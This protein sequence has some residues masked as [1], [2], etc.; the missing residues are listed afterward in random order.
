M[1]D[2][3]LLELP[4][5]PHCDDDRAGPC[6][7]DVGVAEPSHVPRQPPDPRWAALSEL[8]LSSTT[9]KEPRWPSPSARPPGRRPAVARAANWR[10]EAPPR[11]LCPNCGAVKLPHVVC[12]NCGWYRG[13]QVIEVD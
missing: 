2:T 7:P 3:V 8:D 1:R 13:R 6:T 11:S 9:D 12:D 4:L 5:A 10:L